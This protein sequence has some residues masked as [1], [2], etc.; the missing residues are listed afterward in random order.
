MNFISLIEKNCT[1]YIFEHKFDNLHR[2]N[3]R[4]N[5][6]KIYDLFTPIYILEKCKVY[7]GQCWFAILNFDLGAMLQDEN[8]LGIY[9]AQLWLVF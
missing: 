1:I 3:P 2:K 4:Y 9:L 8:V 7:N 5:L 6:R